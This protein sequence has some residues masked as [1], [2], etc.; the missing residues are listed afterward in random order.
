MKLDAVIRV[1]DEGSFRALPKDYLNAHDW[2]TSEDAVF[3][4]VYIVRLAD[5]ELQASLPVSSNVA[6]EWEDLGLIPVYYYDCGN[7]Y[8]ASGEYTV[9]SNGKRY[10]I[11]TED[12]K[13]YF[14]LKSDKRDFL[15]MFNGRFYFNL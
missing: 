11:R 6:G 4:T 5:D 10:E 8:M 7:A 13:R 14:V 3:G 1:L 9:F 2:S 12:G 15:Y